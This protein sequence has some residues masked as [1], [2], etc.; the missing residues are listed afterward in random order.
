V[1]RFLQQLASV[2]GTFKAA[3]RGPGPLARRVVRQ[4]AHREF[5]KALRRVVKP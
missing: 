2:L 5:G 4:R 3:S 1:I